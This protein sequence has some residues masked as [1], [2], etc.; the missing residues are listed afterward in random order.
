MNSFLYFKFFSVF[1]LWKVCVYNGNY[2]PFLE[3]VSFIKVQE[4]L[5]KKFMVSPLDSNSGIILDV[6]SGSNDNAVLSVFGD[7]L[8]TN[9]SG[10]GLTDDEEKEMNRV[11]KNDCNADVFSYLIVVLSE[12][13]VTLKEYEC[14]LK[15]LE[16]TF[17]ACRNYG[18]LMRRIRKCNEVEES[19]RHNRRGGR[20]T[21]VQIKKFTGKASACVN[22]ISKG[23]WLGG[24]YTDVSNEVSGVNCTEQEL[25]DETCKLTNYKVQH[26][27]VVAAFISASV[28]SSK[29][30]EKKRCRRPN[31][32]CK[33]TFFA[34]DQIENLIVEIEG[35]IAEKSAFV[36]GCTKY[37]KDTN[38]SINNRGIQVPPQEI[39]E[40]LKEI[41]QV[42]RLLTDVY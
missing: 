23:L 30:K 12:L 6:G 4:N 17:R 33:C 25:F 21:S 24:K 13:L 28:A 37:L 34:I 9:F 14:R 8:S 26:K 20:D 35:K 15:L 36:R 38:G 2:D 1:F 42:S 41:T 32:R 18:T 7:S 29:C 19:Y 27:V 16:K 10:I 40:G 3:T 5:D 22:A 39:D 11:F 31:R